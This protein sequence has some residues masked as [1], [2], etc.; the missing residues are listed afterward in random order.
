MSFP[1]FDPVAREMLRRGRL[2]RWFR[3]VWHYKA[4]Y[5]LTNKPIL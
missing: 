5:L 4:A 1:F 2:K 3:D